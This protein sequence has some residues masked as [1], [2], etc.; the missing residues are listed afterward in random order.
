[1]RLPVGPL[2]K[3]GIHHPTGDKRPDVGVAQPAH[4]GKKEGGNDEVQAHNHVQVGGDL[5]VGTEAVG[6]KVGAVDGWMDKGK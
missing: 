2:Q 1:M 3:V 4:G 6:V 5:A